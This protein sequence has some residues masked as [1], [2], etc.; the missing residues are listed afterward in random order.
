MSDVEV[1][2]AKRE[3][4]VLDTATEAQVSLLG[5][6]ADLIIESVNLRHV[7]REKFM[8]DTVFGAEGLG[9]DSVDILEI[10]IALEQKY[11][12]KFQD[13]EVARVHLRNMGALVQFIAS[14]KTGI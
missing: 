1:Q 14:K 9:L 4:I 10:V 8:F 2:N 12:F 3:D 13:S 11:N 5:E 6:L 7:P